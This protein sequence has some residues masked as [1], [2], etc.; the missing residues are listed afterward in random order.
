MNDIEKLY[1]AQEVQHLSEL[2]EA[3]KEKLQEQDELL[4]KL[5]TPPLTYGVSVK[6]GNTVTLTNP[7]TTI[8]KLT[9]KGAEVIVRE[10]SDFADQREYGIGKVQGPSEDTYGW[11]DVKFK[12]TNKIHRYRVGISDCD[13]GA[14]DLELAVKEVEQIDTLTVLTKEGFIEVVKPLE[15]EVTEG[16]TVLLGPSSQIIEVSKGV[17]NGDIV[18]VRRIV[19]DIYAEVDYQASTRLIFKGKFKDIQKGDRVVLDSNACIILQNLGKD[20]ESFKFT[21]KTNVTWDDIGGLI[22]AKK[23]M[24][25]AVEFP[26]MHPKLYKFYNKR[27]IKGVLLWG[28]PGNGKTM[29]GKAAATSLASIYQGDAGEFIYVKGPEILDKYVGVAE[30]TIRHIFQRARKHKQDHGYP[31]VI[32]IDEADAILA[33]RGTGVSSDVEK[34]IVPMFLAEMDGLEESD[35]LVI[36][37]TNRPDILDPA[38]V[39]DGRIDR[40]IKITRPTFE[41]TKDILRLNIKNIP[42]HDGF[43]HEELVIHC[44]D[45]LF[46]PKRQLYQIHTKTEDIIPFPLAAVISGSMVAGVIDKATSNALHRDLANKKVEGEGLKREDLTKAIDDIEK[47][48]KELNHDDD[49]K[50]FT[51][52]FKDS[53]SEIK[54]VV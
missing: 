26:H 44:T 15:K 34:T 45:E 18:Y 19:D 47:Q 23:D 14:C 1:T 49:L 10:D 17:P 21:S 12:S 28:P 40:K 9:K 32:F 30:A 41:S 54:K 25:E 8:K 51:S 29:M 11:F 13:D 7:K 48:N 38:I 20:D 27:Q 33:K 42:L 24:I 39:R 3:A 4:Q 22:Q 52:S 43:T 31:A 53:V 46:S 35:S 2:L 5:T 16:D 50:D 37:A 6:T 36:L